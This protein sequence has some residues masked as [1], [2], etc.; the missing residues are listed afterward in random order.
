M[1]LFDKASKQKWESGSV[2]APLFSSESVSLAESSIGD[3]I[4]TASMG[5]GKYS[6]SYHNRTGEVPQWKI[7]FDVTLVSRPTL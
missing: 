3:D 7:D 1:Y 5:W 6:F 2:I 4:S